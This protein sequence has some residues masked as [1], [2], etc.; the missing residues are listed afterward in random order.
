MQS[1]HVH[2]REKGCGHMTVRFFLFLFLCISFFVPK[3]IFAADKIVV[4]YYDFPGFIEEKNQDYYGY[5]I[6]YLHELSNYTKWEYSFVYG[7]MEECCEMVKSGQADL[8]WSRGNCDDL[9]SELCLSEYEIC[10]ET[11]SLVT[12][13]KTEQF[14]YEDFSSFNGMTIAI[15]DY[16]CQK[17]AMQ[18]Y[19][20]IN[21]FTYKALYYKTESELYEALNEKKA[22][23]VLASNLSLQNNIKIIGEV[24]YLNNYLITNKNNSSLMAEIDQTVARIKSINQGFEMKLYS[25]YFGGSSINTTLSL[26]REE[27]EYIKRKGAITIG[28]MSDMYPLSGYN[29]DSQT[30]T[31]INEDIFDLLSKNIGLDFQYVAVPPESSPI[32]FLLAGEVDLIGGIVQS[33]DYIMRT[34]LVMTEPYYTSMMVVVGER[35]KT[36]SF[37]QKNIIAIPAFYGFYA[38]TSSIVYPQNEL[39]LCRSCING[40][41]MIINNEADLAIQDANIVSRMLQQQKY[42]NLV[43]LPYYYSIEEPLTFAGSAKVDPELIS[44]LNKAM[45][46]LNEDSVN[47]IV[48]K[49]TIG[50]PYRATLLDFYLKYKYMLLLVVFM[51]VAFAALAIASIRLKQTSVRELKQKNQY[52]EEANQRVEHASKVKSTFLSH[53][54]HEIRTPM[55]AIIGLTELIRQHL[56][57]KEM[58][59]EYVSKTVYSSKVLMNIIN[60]VLDMSALENNKLKISKNHFSVKE[61]ISSIIALYKTQCEQKN[62]KLDYRF[63]VTMDERIGDPLRISQ[64]LINLLSNAIKFTDSEGIISITISEDQDICFGNEKKSNKKNRENT[65]LN[66]DENKSIDGYVRIVPDG[67]FNEEEKKSRKKKAE[68]NTYENTAIWN[69]LII[70]VSDTGCGIAEDMLSRIFEAFEQENDDTTQKF[71]GSGLGLS[72]VKNLIQL[73]N[74]QLYIRSKKSVGTSIRIRLPIEI[75]N[76]YAPNVMNNND[77][78]SLP[79]ESLEHFE[80]GMKILLAED[81]DINREIMIEILESLGVEA[82]SVQNGRDAYEEFIL[83]R[84]GTYQGIFMDI[85]MPVMDGLTATNKIRHSLHPQ[86]SSIPIYAISANIVLK[87]ENITAQDGLDGFLKKPVDITHLKTALTTMYYSKD[88]AEYE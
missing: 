81:N 28:Q 55:N 72:I 6:D 31:G 76:E 14:F 86:A 69:T 67:N 7:T 66:Y 61:V 57:D 85:Q 16:D 78:F 2:L 12:N 54:S 43:I 15:Q 70:D 58:L 10:T 25:L 75:A 44:I 49:H 37:D 30:F 56:D 39:R 1:L 53:V 17:M 36:Y 62:I 29:E 21:N 74:G 40:M 22:D 84:P 38:K 45:L 87:E 83:A 13:N 5:G 51:I 34:N 35:G 48:M 42:S 64:I 33:E 41:D 4:A 46:V 73:M 23:A 88:L 79:N 59:D 9:L 52:L 19:A 77:V 24:A 65:D 47:Q 8:M 63:L 26:T 68:K 80:Q 18:E 11:L 20:E 82:M 27:N 60:D 71:G 50:S 3:P 32:R